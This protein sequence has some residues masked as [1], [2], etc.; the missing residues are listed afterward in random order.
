MRLRYLSTLVLVPALASGQRADTTT[1]DPVVVSATRIPTLASSLSQPVT[2]LDGDRLRAEGV[3]TVAEA[4]RQAPGLAVVQSGSYG[5]VTSVFMRGGES[6]Y[7]KVLVDGTPVNAVGGIQFFENLSLDNVDRIEIVYGPS[8]ALYGADAVSG[9]IQIFTRR[10]GGPLAIDADGR[11]GSYGSRDGSLSLRGGSGIVSYSL[12][13]GWHS[14]DGVAAFNNS[15]SNGDLNGALTLRPDGMSTIGITTRYTGSL[16]HFPTDYTGAVNDSTSYTREH[17]FVAGLDASR[18]LATGV[19]F[20]LLGGDNEIHGLS[21]DTKSPGSGGA[22]HTKT[23]APVDGFRRFGEARF[24]ASLGSAGTA[25]AGAQYQVEEQS[26]R[27]VSVNFASSTSG[28]TPVTTPGTANQ[29]RTRGYYVALQGSPADAIAYDLSARHDVH[30]DFGSVTTFHAGASAGLWRDARLKASYGTGFNAPAFYQTQGSVYNAP[31]AALQPEQSHSLDVRLEQTLFGGA[32][33]FGAGGFD[34]RF[35]NQIQYVAGSYGGPPDYAELAPAYYANLTQARAKGYQGELSASL[36][37]GLNATAAYTQTIAQ[38]YAVPPAYGGSQHSGDALLR[39]PS[40]SAMGTLFYAP[41]VAWSV[42]ASADYV[43][44]RPDMDFSRY[45]SPTL[46]LP[47]YVKVGVSGSVRI[48][49]SA[50]TSVALVG[51]VDNALDR[52]YADVYNF[53]APGRA[54][55]IGAR[56]SAVR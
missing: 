12:G 35:S 14:T 41:S 38:V 26:S 6:R 36:P 33:R 51:R 32:L 48:F 45:P 25:T 1:L 20:R 13:G 23:I 46:T 31:N 16:Y 21:E 17:R 24:E 37:G 49:T 9:V 15:Y 34:Q 3:T 56:L 47:S 4:L 42:G 52:H 55:F 2:V 50:G 29:R 43:G 28:V 18:R 44:K 39:R 11:A 27:T 5:G 54:V 53:P 19:K 30:S 7:T 40:H 10:G 22:A 8:S